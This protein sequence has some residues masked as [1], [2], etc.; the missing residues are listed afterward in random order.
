MIFCCPCWGRLMLED[1]ELGHGK[2][3]CCTHRGGITTNLIESSNFRVSHLSKTLCFIKKVPNYVS[4]DPHSSTKSQIGPQS[5]LQ[6]CPQ[7][8]H[9]SK[10]VLVTPRL[11]GILYCCQEIS[12]QLS[13]GFHFTQLRG[14]PLASQCPSPQECV[15]F[16]CLYCL[17]I[18]FFLCVFDGLQFHDG[19]Q[20]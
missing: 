4:L 17:H 5:A 16:V 7:C 20:V 13:Q 15:T 9:T 10:Q 14:P 12:Y 6:H 19:I 2:R 3:T 11:S 1:G 8:S 18:R